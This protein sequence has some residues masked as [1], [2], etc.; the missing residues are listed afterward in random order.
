MIDMSNV[1]ANVT[2]TTPL[3]RTTSVP[4]TT[5]ESKHYDPLWFFWLQIILLS[6]LMIVIILGNL[7]VLYCLRSIK[8]MR[9]ITGLFLTNLAVTDLG[10]G[11]VS[12]PLSLAASVEHFYLHSEWFCSLQ[13]SALVLFVLASLLTLGALSLQKYV[14]VGYSTFN[15]FTK[16][17]AQ[18][19]IAM[20]WIVSTI[21]AVAPVF[22]WSAYSFSKGGHQC[23]PYVDSVSGYT[24]LAGLMTI[25]III[26][27]ITMLFCYCKLYRMTRC[28]ARRMRASEA[29]HRNKNCD[30]ILSAVESHMIHTLIIMMIAFFICWLPPIVMFLFK[31]GQQRIPHIFEMVV[32][33][34]ASGNSAVNPI[35]YAMRQR[36]FQKGFR[37][38]LKTIFSRNRVEDDSQQRPPRRVNFKIMDNF[39]VKMED[40]ETDA[41]T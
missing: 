37:K 30:R 11:F 15:R 1:S 35:L 22:G 27:T 32:V 21:F 13:G 25:G 20:I 12:L 14:N 5:G 8:E 36:D 23:A 29:A 38:I 17:H 7:M 9:T 16:R 28:H 4:Q 19:T 31:V 6:L 39:D 33:V 10:V 2:P 26:P 34:C 40:S 24:H 3:L 18:M 41:A